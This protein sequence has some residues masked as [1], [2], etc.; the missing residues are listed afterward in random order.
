MQELAAAKSSASR[1]ADSGEVAAQLKSLQAENQA[2]KVGLSPGL[3]FLS[4][5]SEL[6]LFPRNDSDMR[7][8][9][10]RFG[11]LKLGPRQVAGLL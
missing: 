6:L 9:G 11:C 10:C 1:D 4:S 5:T 7:V 2:L 3:N 8:D